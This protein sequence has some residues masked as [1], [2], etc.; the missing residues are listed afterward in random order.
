MG[1]C[2]LADMMNTNSAIGTVQLSGINNADVQISLL[3]RTCLQE[4]AVVII[5]RLGYLN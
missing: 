4:C 1:D 3:L 5:S 2:M